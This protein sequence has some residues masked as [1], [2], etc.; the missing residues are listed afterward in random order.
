MRFSGWFGLDLVLESATPPTHIWEKSFKKNVFFFGGGLP[1]WRWWSRRQ[2]WWEEKE[3]RT[4]PAGFASPHL[5]SCPNHQ[6]INNDHHRQADDQVLYLCL[7]IESNQI[8]NI[9]IQVSLSLTFERGPNNGRQFHISESINGR[10]QRDE[11]KLVQT[12]SVDKTVKL[13]WL[14]P[15]TTSGKWLST[16]ASL[17]P[18]LFQHC[19]VSLGIFVHPT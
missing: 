5:L 9:I 17:V 13:F 12:G 19:W 11:F 1:L 18:I 14:P 3:E 2:R 8:Q 15:D 6:Q 4:I 16:V 7:H 10:I